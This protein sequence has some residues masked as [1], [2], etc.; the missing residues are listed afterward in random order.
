VDRIARLAAAGTRFVPRRIP[1]GDPGAYVATA[2][3]QVRYRY[4]TRAVFH[5]SAEEVRRRVPRTFGELE[6]L[7]AERCAHRTG[8]D[9]LDWLVIQLSLPGVDFTIDGPPELRDH[10]ARLSRRYAEAAAPP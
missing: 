6:A 2:L 7:D 4:E 3:G 5:A 9:D 1:G 10:L 8:N